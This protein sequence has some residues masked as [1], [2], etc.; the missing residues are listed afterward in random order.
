MI[1]WPQPPNHT[2]SCDKSLFMQIRAIPV[3]WPRVLQYT[4][5]V[6]V[7]IIRVTI[8]TD[9]KDLNMAYSP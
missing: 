4:R 7:R 3:H 2:P 1:A 8:R 6:T 9:R 5:T